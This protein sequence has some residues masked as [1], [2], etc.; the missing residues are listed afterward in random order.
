[1]VTIKATKSYFN[2]DETAAYGW[3]YA[4]DSDKEYSFQIRLMSPIYEGSVNPVSGN[5]INI[6]ANDWSNGA[7]ITDAM[8]KGADYNKN[9]YNVVP[10]AA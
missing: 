6:S 3:N 9:T 4:E 1:M 10:D 8:I 7:R 5:T 2:T